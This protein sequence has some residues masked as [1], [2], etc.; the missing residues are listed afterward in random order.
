MGKVRLFVQLTEQERSKIEVLLQQRFSFRRIAG[1][2][3]RSVST[4]SRE[5]RRNQSVRGMRPVYDSACIARRKAQLRH[6]TKHKRI[7]FDCRMKG[8]I[9]QWLIDERFSP[10]L[11]SVRGRKDWC[12]FV[13]HEWIYQWIWRMKKSMCRAD[14]PYQQLYRY[15]RHARRRRHRGRRRNMRG[16]ILERKWIDQRPLQAN[17]RREIGHLEGDIMLGKDRQP[18]NLVV[19]DR[20]SRKCW[21]S[22]LNTKDAPYVVKKLKQICVDAQAKTLTLDND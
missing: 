8:Q 21:I 20:K 10:E 9:V 16:N 13:S 11:I 15:L 22:K 1:V 14:E 19:L 7:F 18:G 5:V 2:L 12:S 6:R 3:N 4:V 17:Q